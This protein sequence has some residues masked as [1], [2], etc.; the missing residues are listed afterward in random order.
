MLCRGTY[1]F[2]F[3]LVAICALLLPAPGRAQASRK[4]STH[5]ASNRYALFLTDAPVA[6]R[7][8]SRDALQAND[9]QSYRQ[10]IEARQQTLIDTLKAR[11]VAVTGSV[12]TVL[13]AVFVEL[14]PDRV[15]EMKGLPGV[16]GVVRMRR[17]ERHLNQA[18]QLMNAPAA[19]NQLGGTGNAGAG[20]KVAVIDTG[21]DQT[22]PSFQ[23]STLSMPAG[24][25]K[26]TPGDCAFTNNK[27]IVARSYVKEIGAGMD[28]NNPAAT[29][30]PDDFSARDHDG[31]G[32]AVASVVAAN[33]SSGTVTFNGMAPKAYLGAYKVYGSPGVNDYPT[34][35]IFILAINDAMS[36]GMDIVNFS[37]G[38]SSVSGPLDT[39]S[40]CGNAAGVPCDPL[41]QAFENAAKSGLVITVSAGNDGFSGSAY[42][43]FNIIS[44]PASAPSVISVGATTNSHVFGPAVSVLG[45]P[46][47]LQNILAQNSD[48][49]GPIGA[50]TAP[51]VDVSQL[52]N[53]GY[54]CTAL[55]A[56]SLNG[57]FA[58]IERGPAGNACNFAVKAANAQNAGAIGAIFYMYDGSATIT[59][60]FRGQVN[61]GLFVMISNAD[62]TNLK[63]Y[64]DANPGHAVVVDPAGQQES[65]T[66]SNQLASYSSVGPNTGNYAI[67]PELVAT[68]GFD[69]DNGPDPLDM[70]LFY[71]YGM[72][73]AAENYDPNGELYSSNRYTAADGTSFSSPIT[74]GAAALLKQKNPKLTAAEIKS[75]LVNS[76][77]QDTTTEDFFN[78][79]VSVEWIGAGRLNAGSAIGQ[80]V[81]ANPTTVSFGV[82]SNLP[83]TQQITLTN[84][85]SSSVTLAA[86]TVPHVS[87]SNATVTVS[88]AS[89]TLAAGA[90]GTITVSLTGTTPTPGAYD[91]RIDLTGAGVLLHIPYL[92][93][94]G[95]GVAYDFIPLVSGTIDDVAGTDVGV[96]NFK[97]IDQYGVPVANSPVSFSVDGFQGG[98]LT[99]NSV[100]GGVPACTPATAMDAVTCPTDAN[101]VAWVD[102]VLGT[103]GQPL[104][105]VSDAIGDQLQIDFYIRPQPTISSGGV[106][107]AASN[108]APIAAGSYVSIYGANL[109]DPNMTGNTTTTTLPLV[110]NQVT[111]SFDTP[112]ASISVP[113]YLIYESPNQVN[114]QVPWELQGQTSAQ[115][116]VTIDQF[117]Y[118]NVVTVPLAIYSPAFYSANGIVSA[119]DANY[120]QISA[121]HPAMHGQVLQLFGNGLGPVNNQPASGVPALSSPLSTTKVVPTVSIG[122]QN[123]PVS[124]SGLAPGFPSLNQ[125]NVTVPA[126]LAPGTYPI[127]MTIG[128]VTSPAVNVPVQ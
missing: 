51:L 99:L 36:D 85:G 98:T 79:P 73:V 66:P 106:V 23:D 90:S 120:A 11:N 87:S 61:P 77:A 93:L 55:P 15:E 97:V 30:S 100:P 47:N 117:S 95:S 124:F 113:G 103:V 37:S 110:I 86:T 74:A 109:A 62:G 80:T 7:Y 1:S 39:G 75:A 13:N 5:A 17:G 19:W 41:A 116:K 68:G 88:P 102:V 108:T 33:V 57:A 52:G 107:N 126:G 10:Q 53:D 45:T 3:C 42:P 48:G 34:E 16:M 125:I 4:R 46:S 119:L 115:V 14:T 65:I 64:I 94:K 59:P 6:V 81:F 2:S 20:I 35:D 92:F 24:F 12:S 104:L 127:I 63:T 101:G 70:Y 123:A 21:I 71:G 27:V 44:S 76:A 118:G 58:L 114:V 31:H 105:L 38:L 56:G 72:Y 67:K 28:P 50:L 112:S 122:G 43:A 25:P 69:P 82:A 121:S 128:G 111:V 26:C 49:F 29:S 9:A 22:H 96:L 83:M 60:E 18:V 32:T 91:G 84:S 40:V 54:A 89:I 78:D 8:A